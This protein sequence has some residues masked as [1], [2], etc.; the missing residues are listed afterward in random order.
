MVHDGG[1]GKVSP[2][3]GESLRE[4]LCVKRF[5]GAADDLCSEL[6]EIFA[7]GSLVDGVLHNCW[8]VCDTSESFLPVNDAT[9]EGRGGCYGVGR[10]RFSG[11]PVARVSKIYR[12][13]MAVEAKSMWMLMSLEGCRL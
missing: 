8:L 5:D 7:T 12:P 9:V 2:R 13:V 1:P 4:C 6:V 10:Q 3:E 11:V